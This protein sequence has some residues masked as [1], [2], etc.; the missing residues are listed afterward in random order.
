MPSVQT[1]PPHHALS[2]EANRRAALV[3][4]SAKLFRNKGFKATT[5]RDIAAAV[6]MSSGSPFYHF[7]N[8]EEILKAVMEQGLRQGLE[9]TTHALAQA[10]TAAEEFRILVQTHYGILHHPGSDFIAVMI[11]EWRQ[12]PD[13]HKRDIIA[14]KDRYDGLW[15]HTLSRLIQQGQ[16]GSQAHGN[17]AVAGEEKM[18]RLMV[19]GAINYSVTWFKEQHNS[20]DNNDWTLDKLCENTVAFF[21]KLP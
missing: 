16:L 5:V 20:N 10:H 18:A 19:L 8:K 12:L 21:L 11:Y 4:A 7:A 17:P 3:R 15:H 9:L 2:D 6:G 14:L 1:A 13:S